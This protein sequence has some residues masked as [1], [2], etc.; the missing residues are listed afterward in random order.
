M[1]PDCR[2]AYEF[3]LSISI[4]ETAETGSDAGP[5]ENVSRRCA[6]RMKQMGLV[7]DA[8][9]WT[10]LVFFKAALVADEKA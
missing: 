5:P 10:K 6:W 7:L 2:S 1:P 8:A 9:A 4:W 3:P